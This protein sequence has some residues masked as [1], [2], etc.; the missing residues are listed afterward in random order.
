METQFDRTRL[1]LGEEALQTLARARVAVFGLGG[2]GGAAAEALARAGIGALDL[3]DNDA[4]ALSN[5]N[6]QLI[7][8]HET[9]GLRKTEAAAVR[10]KAIN[11]ACSVKTHDLFYLPDTADALDL[12]QY[13]YIIDAVDTVTA[14]LTLAERAQSLG[15]PLISSMG[16][17]NKL[18]P[19]AFRVSDLF[20]T[21]GDPLARVMRRECRKRGV[22][23]LKVV[24]SPEP[25]LQ[26]EKAEGTGAERGVP[27]SV[28]FVPPVAG[29]IL[30]AEVVRDLIGL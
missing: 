29:F 3:V 26:P 20:Q 16:T 18:N 4:V 14:K 5:L 15:V 19:A 10:V 9:L 1:L 17:G 25:P 2:V 6:R 12:S 23:K 8:T 21:E 28:P 30:A 11:P 7:A 22:K 27:G 24:W 13:N